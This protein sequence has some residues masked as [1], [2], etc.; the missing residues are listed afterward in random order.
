MQF[1]SRLQPPMTKIPEIGQLQE[2]PE[3]AQ[4]VRPK[5]M[6][7]PQ[8]NGVKRKT[9]AEQAGETGR[10]APP[11]PGSRVSHNSI[12]GGSLASLSRQNSYASSVSSSRPASAASSSFRNASSSS[13]FSQSLGP[14][15]SHS[16][17][18]R[19]H[20][21]M[22]SYSNGSKYGIANHRPTSS[23]EQN[24]RS[25]RSGSVQGANTNSMRKVSSSRQPS[26][27]RKREP[28]P[29]ESSDSQSECAPWPSS[30]ENI[31]MRPH[32]TSLREISLSTRMSNMSLSDHHVQQDQEQ[33]GHLKIDRICNAPKTPSQIPK[34]KR[35]IQFTPAP[36]P[37]SETISP[38]KSPRKTP[39]RMGF[40]LNK[41]TNIQAADWD[42]NNRIERVESL[43]SE[44]KDQL[45]AANGE[46][47]NFKD[48]LSLLK[49]RSM[50]IV[51][52]S[53]RANK[54]SRYGYG[55]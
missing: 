5:G 25:A 1:K 48:T 47:D 23:L 50:W 33:E 29:Q 35:S 53:N 13:T 40:F 14:S 39:K 54:M 43:Y 9:L 4:N 32:V 27:S 49:T 45:E 51:R 34:K 31:T 11:P 52:R 17:S 24:G 38:T 7:P 36:L 21:A 44:M 41:S 20:T 18:S 12:K 6:Q 28:T 2:L 42:V 8:V 55:G 19:P 22:S 15:R 46:R 30:F 10:P 16:Q 37:V 3:S 26:T